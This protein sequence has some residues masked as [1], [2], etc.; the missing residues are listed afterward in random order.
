MVAPI[1]LGQFDGEAELDGRTI[2][3]RKAQA[4]FFGGKVAGTLDARLLADPSYEFQGRF[5]RVNLAQLG[6]SVRSLNNRI[7]GTASATL[8]ISTHGI[9]RENLIG[10]MEGNGT[11]NVRNAELPGVDFTEVFPGNDQDTFLSPFVSVEG[12]F[13]IQ[14]KGIDLANFVLDHSQGQLQADGRIDFTHTLN[15]RIRPSIL[16]A[17]TSPAAATPPV[18]LL[19]GTIE[20]PEVSPSSFDAQT[21]GQIRHSRKIV[22]YSSRRVAT[23]D[24]A[25]YHRSM[26]LRHD[27][28]ADCRPRMIKAAAILFWL[29]RGSLLWRSPAE[30]DAAG[31]HRKISSR[32]K[33]SVAARFS[34]A[35]I[36]SGQVFR[37]R[38]GI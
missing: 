38:D 19:T 34:F 28:F 6:L 27:W 23:G 20:N 35:A 9:G 15:L 26:P 18:F 22:T 17:A 37:Y 32:W 13:R 12:A 3:I 14:A 7:A 21:F 25:D 33:N 10:S 30:K 31:F 16:Q 2:R 1:R 4:D 36:F 29:L 5:D 8:S 11:L 24:A